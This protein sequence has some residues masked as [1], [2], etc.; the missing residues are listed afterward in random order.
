[1]IRSTTSGCIF[2]RPGTG[3]PA[4]N[5]LCATWQSATISAP[6]RCSA[7]GRSTASS[8][9]SA[10]ERAGR[11]LPAAWAPL[12]LP[13]DLGAREKLCS[14]QVLRASKI[15]SCGLSA[16]YTREPRPS[17][18]A[19]HWCRNRVVYAG[20]EIRNLTSCRIKLPDCDS[21][22]LFHASSYPEVP[23]SRYR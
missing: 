19:F 3:T 16:S 1:M 11:D 7:S 9:Q 10:G 13:S 23:S 18:V 6:L 20:A 5:G 21:C 17:F 8:L 4:S 12:D 22:S 15:R 14:Y 2:P